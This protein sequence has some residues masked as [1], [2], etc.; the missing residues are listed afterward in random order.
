LSVLNKETTY[1][2]IQTDEELIRQ[3][4]EAIA[5]CCG[6]SNNRVEF[7]NEGSVKPLVGYLASKDPIVHRSTA[8]A[9]HQLSR[10]PDNCISMHTSGVV[11]VNI[12]MIPCSCYKSVFHSRKESIVSFRAGKKL[13]FKRNFL[14]FLIFLGFNVREVSS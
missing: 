3:L 7:G 1:T 13:G 12:P 11:K 6:W 9:L 4:A 14:R 10:D 2:L 8:R 5:R